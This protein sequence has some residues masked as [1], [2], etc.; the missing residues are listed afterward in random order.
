M[1]LPSSC[2][3]DTLAPPSGTHPMHRAGGPIGQGRHP[4]FWATRDFW[5]LQPS[6][7]Q[8]EP[9]QMGPSWC[10]GLRHLGPSLAPLPLPG[11]SSPQCPK[12][13]CV[14]LRLLSAPT[15]SP[16][17]TPA[18]AAPR[19]TSGRPSPSYWA[20]LDGVW[21]LIL[22]GNDDGGALRAA[23]GPP[24]PQPEPPDPSLPMQAP[25]M[26]PPCPTWWLLGGAMGQKVNLWAGPFSSPPE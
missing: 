11:S 20:A 7:L 25:R 18:R 21:S 3:Q 8:A 22:P 13:T 16:F 12:R 19:P 15:S 23:M 26:S 1:G 4:V 2:G 9:P 17:L 5:V 6:L 10:Y 14:C 24:P